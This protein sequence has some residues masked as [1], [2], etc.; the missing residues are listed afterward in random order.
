MLVLVENGNVQ[1][2]ILE[3]LNEREAEKRQ[4]ESALERLTRR[5][6]R[7]IELPTVDWVKNQLE[8]L[9]DVLAEDSRKSAM[10]YRKFFGKVLG[11]IVVAPGKKRGHAEIAFKANRLSA[12]LDVVGNDLGNIPPSD[13]EQTTELE[14]D[15]VRV[16]L[17]G[18]DKLDKLM[19][20][21]DA[22]RQ[23]GKTW[24]QIEAELKINRSW[25]NRYH[26]IWKSEAAAT[27]ES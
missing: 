24:R 6:K 5:K 7:R 21:I 25:A 15:V 13:S 18:N 12:V 14:G 26:R 22:M 16:A 19:P 8:K 2:S 17:A 10:F 23:A 4:L 20:T 11:Y 9:S 27:V 1:A 3:R